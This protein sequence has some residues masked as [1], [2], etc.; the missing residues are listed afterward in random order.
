MSFYCVPQ[1]A[2]N[3]GL[4]VVVAP[5]DELKIESQVYL[6]KTTMSRNAFEIL[7]KDGKKCHHL[8]HM[9]LLISSSKV[10]TLGISEYVKLAKL[11]MC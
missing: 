4:L 6:F 2:F 11:D 3:F 7:K 1:K 5:F 10:F 8:K 9:W